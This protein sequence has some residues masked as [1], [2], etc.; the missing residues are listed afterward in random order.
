MGRYGA[1]TTVLVTTDH[2]RAHNFSDHGPGAPESARVW[3][4]AAS[5]RVPALGPI[6]S[7]RPRVLSDIAPTFRA[8]LGLPPDTDPQAG[9]PIAELL[10]PRAGDAPDASPPQR[11]ASFA[12]DA[13]ATRRPLH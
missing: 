4:L 9:H 2:G 8:L 13:G 6:H 7:D 5:G 10:G 11:L 12:S 3:L 1:E